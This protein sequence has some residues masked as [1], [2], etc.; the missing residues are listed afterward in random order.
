MYLELAKQWLKSNGYSLDM[1]LYYIR[2]FIKGEPLY[3]DKLIQRSS[4][5]EIYFAEP[6]VRKVNTIKSYKPK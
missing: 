3:N 6:K 5:F 4:S 2:K 1:R